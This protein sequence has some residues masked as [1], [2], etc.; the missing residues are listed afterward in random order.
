LNLLLLC[1][2][3]RLMGVRLGVSPEVP[4]DFKPEEH[5]LVRS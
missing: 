5:G 3:F 2:R 4:R 1:Y